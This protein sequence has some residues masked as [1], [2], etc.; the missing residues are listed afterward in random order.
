MHI[1]SRGPERRLVAAFAGRLRH[2]RRTRRIPLKQMA[3]ELGV[4]T[5]IVS[6]WEN[7]TRF[8]T[9]EHLEQISGYTGIPAWQFLYDGPSNRPASLVSK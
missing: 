2:W 6:A 5:A 4:S 3:G 8:P 9:L 7:A 1:D